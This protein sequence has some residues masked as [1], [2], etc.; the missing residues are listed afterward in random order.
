VPTPNVSLVDV[1]YVLKKDT[2]IEEINSIIEKYSKKELLN[3]I[4]I[5]NDMRVSS[6]FC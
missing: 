2:S 1:N 4:E 3:I 6:D 5:D